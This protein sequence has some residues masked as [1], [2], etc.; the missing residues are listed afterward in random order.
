MNTGS[1]DRKLA[2]Q[3]A[4]MGVSKVWV[5]DT[6]RNFQKDPADE[7]PLCGRELAVDQ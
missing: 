1:N 4:V 6:A 2:A 7:E 3:C 5:S